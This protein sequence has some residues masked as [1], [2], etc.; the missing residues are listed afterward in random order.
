MTLSVTIREGPQMNAIDDQSLHDTPK[1]DSDLGAYLEQL[2]RHLDV[3][4]KRAAN[5]DHTRVRLH[6]TGEV[7]DVDSLGVTVVRDCARGPTVVEFLC[8]RCERLHEGT[9]R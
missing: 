3:R 9:Q 7:V 6:C 4:E 5:T 2:W 1:L 8:P